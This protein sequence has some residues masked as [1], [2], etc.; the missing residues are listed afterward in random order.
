MWGVKVKGLNGDISFIKQGPAGKESGQNVP[1]VYVVG[2][3]GG[4]I[5]KR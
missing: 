1:S 4:K 2:I 5:V 3:D